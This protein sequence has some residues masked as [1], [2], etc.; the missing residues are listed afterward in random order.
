M[1]IENDGSDVVCVCVYIYT[2]AKNGIIE[3]VLEEVIIAKLAPAARSP[4]ISR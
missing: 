1:H 2:A 4:L 3:M